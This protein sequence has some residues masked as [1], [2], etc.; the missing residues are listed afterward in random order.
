M[1]FGRPPV[2]PDHPHLPSVEAIVPLDP[3]APTH[4]TREGGERTGLPPISPP[5][6]VLPLELWLHLL[7]GTSLARAGW[8]LVILG[9]LVLAAMAPYTDVVGLLFPGTSARVEG[10]VQEV[11][12]TDWQS[13]EIGANGEVFANRFL[14][15]PPGG[16]SLESVSYSTGRVVEA[17]QQV[18][19]EYNPMN[20][21]R[22]R[23]QG[24]RFRPLGRSSAVLLLPTLVGLVLAGHALFTGHGHARLLE[25]GLATLATLKI[26]RDLSDRAGRVQHWNLEYGFTTPGG[27]VAHLV[28]RTRDAST[29]ADD[30]EVVV[31]Y[32]PAQP[33]RG[34]LFDVLPGRPS[35]E[36]DGSFQVANPV[37]AWMSVLP[38]A[39]AVIMTLATGWYLVSI[40]F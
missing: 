9:A 20:P 19:I 23:I 22:A 4:D 10:V 11:E 7:L 14:F 32:D 30:D 29:L 25:R 31:F 6:R 35:V 26:R 37:T 38:A 8:G 34:V 21:F 36:A 2:P 15:K 5:P 12:A 39:L 13:L 24:Q 18:T 27:D 16:T 28:Y 3:A 40:A 1:T 17:G 33:E